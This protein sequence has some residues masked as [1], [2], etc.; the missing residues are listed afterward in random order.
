MTHPQPPSGPQDPQQPNPEPPP[1]PNPA[2]PPQTAADPT[3]PTAPESPSPWS[4]PPP[5]VF[6]AQQ[7]AAP[8]PSHGGEPQ[9]PSV[10]EQ[11]PPFS[12]A[13][14]PPFTGAPQPP[15][16]SDQ[17]PFTGAPQPTPPYSS[18]PYSSPSGPTPPGPHWQQQA[19]FAAGGYPPAGGGGYPPPTGPG[20]PPPTGPGYPPGM[21]PTATGA[22]STKTVLIIV[23][24][25][26]V[27]A[28]LCCVGG[29]VT[30]VVGANRTANETIESIPELGGPAPAPSSTGG[31]SMN[32][33]AGN[34]AQIDDD[35][36][37]MKVTVTK[38]STATE[39][40]RTSGLKPDKGMYLI[41]D[42]TVSIVEGTGTINQLYFWWIAADGTKTSAIAG[43]LSGCGTSLRAGTNLPAGT[44]HTGTIVFNVPDTNGTLEY[45]H[46]FRTA[47]SWKP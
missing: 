32:M 4:P 1:Q 26:A 45:Q 20:Y 9:Q 27:L 21:P 14:Q 39:P 44:T 13:P 17:P 16:A 24:I 23:V 28:L 37:V 18:P 36:G 31:P 22:N 19:P 30:M 40:C 5:L 34:S 10:N 6:G 25:A 46:R 12:S 41:A 3:A 11:P 7:P 38:F 33:P 43:V 35:R 47:A 15:F 29:I 8:Q 42:V 2:T